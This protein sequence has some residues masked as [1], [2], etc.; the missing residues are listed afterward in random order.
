MRK[1][2]LIQLYEK[3]LRFSK[4]ARIQRLGRNTAKHLYLK[5]L[6]YLASWLEIPFE[7]KT[8]TFWNEKMYV[9]IP[10][11]IS[12]DIYRHG[13]YE[14]GLTRM[15]LEYLTAGMV[16]FDIGAHFGYFTLLGS[17]VV[18]NSGQVHAFEPIP[19][20][21]DILK[22][23]VSGR[24]N[25]SLNNYAVYSKEDVFFI[26]DYGIKY[27]AF[28][29]L[30]N[31]RLSQNIV[32]RVKAKKHKVKSVSVDSY[33]DSTGAVPDFVK[34]D[35]ESSEYEILL[36]MQKTIKRY[37]PMISVEV[38]D[39]AVKGASTSSTLINFLVNT[40]YKPY[41]YDRGRILTHTL[42]RTQYRYDNLL[43]IPSK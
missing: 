3:S 21:F 1:T 38:G 2:E 10:E 15:I 12:L 18:G 39:M 14:E 43:F 5:I 37:H 27:S 34:I 8:E 11:I 41:E 33:V 9:V 25:V 6:T 29:S 23:N 20:T 42:K 24:C 22:K 26:N 32:S 28:N 36:G 17:A 31:A 16:F 7:I 4:H 19:H 40:G 30:Y 35:A 13:F